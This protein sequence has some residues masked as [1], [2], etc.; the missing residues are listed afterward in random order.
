M[1]GALDGRGVRMAGTRTT[2]LCRHD[3]AR[4]ALVAAPTLA[5][6]MGR[7]PSAAFAEV[8]GPGEAQTGEVSPSAPQAGTDR[9]ATLWTTPALA[10]G[11]QGD[12]QSLTTLTLGDGCVCFGTAR[13]AQKDNEP[14]AD[15]TH[16]TEHTDDMA[17]APLNAL[18]PVAG[19]VAGV[20]DLA[21]I[22]FW[23]FRRRV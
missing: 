15:A 18:L 21:G 7:V 11:V 10:A 17:D 5:M 3:I 13:D 20:I 4:R 12:Q 22:G 16:A 23:S 8:R 1:G 19:M 14:H 2:A 6:T 9:L